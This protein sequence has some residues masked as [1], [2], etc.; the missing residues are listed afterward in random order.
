[1]NQEISLEKFVDF[2]LKAEFDR[3]TNRLGFLKSKNV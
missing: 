3:N 1:M 2:L